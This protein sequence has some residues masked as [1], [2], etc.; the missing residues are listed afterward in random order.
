M[1]NQTL[2]RAGMAFYRPHGPVAPTPEPAPAAS[3]GSVPPWRRPGRRRRRRP[4][5]RSRGRCGLTP[6][7]RHP[8]PAAVCRSGRRRPPRRRSLAALPTG[9]GGRRRL[10]PPCIPANKVGIRPPWMLTAKTRPLGCLPRPCP[11]GSADRNR[12][13]NGCHPDPPAGD[14]SFISGMRHFFLF[15]QGQGRGDGILNFLPPP[16]SKNRA[17][18]TSPD[19]F[20]QRL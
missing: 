4:R 11:D 8:G 6:G 15:S 7:R 14:L 2:R 10:P 20:S 17:A 9:A 1:A 16:P 19:V 5:P 12:D 18:P 13:G 3:T